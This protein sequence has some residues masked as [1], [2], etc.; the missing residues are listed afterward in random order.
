MHSATHPAPLTI[1]SPLLGRLEEVNKELWVMLT[2]FAICLLLNQLVASQRMVLSFYTIPTLMSAYSYGRRHATL[3][4]LASV[5]VVALMIMFNPGMF[6]GANL[7]WQAQ[8]LDLTAWG[9]IL[10]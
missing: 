3:T 1:K 7:P 2:L 5:L 4:A 8:W 9:S 10:I 6:A